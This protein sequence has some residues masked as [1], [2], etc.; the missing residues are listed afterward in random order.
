MTGVIFK[1]ERNT[2]LRKTWIEK[3]KNE[4]A[5]KNKEFRPNFNIGAC[6]ILEEY[7]NQNGYNI[8]HALNGGEYYIEELG[9]WVDGYDK[10]QNIVVEYYEKWHSKTIDKDNKR[11]EEITNFLKCK[12]I[13]I[14]E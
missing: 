8:Q 11:E 1:D 5:V 2:K 13:K 9:Y 12:F 14:Y 7:G 6:Q 3:Y 4:Y 10:E